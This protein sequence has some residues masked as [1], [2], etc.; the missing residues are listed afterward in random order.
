MLAT[1]DLHELAQARTP[2]TRLVGAARPLRTG[3]PE[4]GVDHPVAQRLARD[5]DVV[6]LRKL[7]TRQRRAEIRVVTSHA[8]DS[9]LTNGRSKLPIT[10]T[11]AL[12]RNKPG[13]AVRAESTAQSLDLAQAQ[14]QL[15]CSPLLRQPTFNHTADELQAVKFF[16]TH[17]QVSRIAHVGLQ[18]RERA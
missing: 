11:S 18:D 17:R 9:P 5:A 7:L 3:D 10:R 15:V 12:V 2:L 14:T 4:P 6:P 8:L 13:C 1:V 16:G